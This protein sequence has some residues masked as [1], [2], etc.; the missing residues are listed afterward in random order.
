MEAFR[1][2]MIYFNRGEYENPRFWRGFGGKPF[3]KDASVLDIGCGYG[4][5]CIDMALSGAKRVIGIDINGQMIEF[6][7]ENL[8]QNYPQLMHIVEFR[9]V[10]LRDFDCSKF[11]FN[12]IV[13]KDTFEHLFDLG[14]VLEKT[15]EILQPGGGVYVGF[16]PLYNS[17]FGDHGWTQTLIPWGHLV[18]KESKI[19]ER[20]NRNRAEKINSI[21]NLALNKMSLSAYRRIFHESGL[22][23]VYFKVNQN[24][25]VLSIVSKIFYWMSRIPFLEEFF[26][27]NL[28]CILEK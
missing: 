27:H 8:K 10:S 3:L 4:S 26:T 2:H 12:F 23:I 11:S 15:K 5:L 22:S 28:Y 25:G 24:V 1:Q 20:L 18:F 14:G 17:P 16:G 7:V 9:N 13:S 21:A 6:A 19:I